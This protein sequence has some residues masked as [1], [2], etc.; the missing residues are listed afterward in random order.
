MQHL[1]VLASY[2]PPFVILIS[3]M[4]KECTDSGVAWFRKFCIE[5]DKDKCDYRVGSFQKTRFLQD[6]SYFSYIEKVTRRMTHR[7]A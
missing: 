3:G 6:E 1:T 5:T 7:G 2:F 4:C